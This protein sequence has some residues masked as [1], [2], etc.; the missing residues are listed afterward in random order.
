LFRV[1]ADNAGAPHVIS[2]SAGNQSITA[3]F[4]PPSYVGG[5]NPTAYRLEATIVGTTD[6]FVNP[7]C[8]VS[9][10]P[11]TCTIHGLEN[12]ED[13]K[14]RVAAIN[15]AGIGLYSNDSLEMTPT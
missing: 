8:V 3:L 13:Y 4:N 12:D 11:I 14:V 5:A 15:E 2:V 6:R 1:A 10:A 9:S 7:G